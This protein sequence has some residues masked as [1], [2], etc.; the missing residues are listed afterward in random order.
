MTA[1]SPF[2]SPARPWAQPGDPVIHFSDPKLVAMGKRYNKSSAQ[3]ILRYVYQLGAIPI[4]KSVNKQRLA[5]NIDIF[6][7]EL[8]KEDVAIIDQFDCGNRG[9]VV[10]A[11]DLKGL[12]HY[13]FEGV[14]F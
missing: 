8:S 11:L 3:V 14:E 5:A 9:R 7:F 2:G 1:Y 12:P 10:P 13:P 6:D 4:P